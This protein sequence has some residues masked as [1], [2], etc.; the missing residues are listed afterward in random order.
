MTEFEYSVFATIRKI[1]KGCVATYGQIARL[2]GHERASRAVGTAL[3]F[4]PDPKGTPCYR[5]VNSKGQL[6]SAF[7]FGGIEKQKE[8]L[9]KDGIIVKNYKVDLSIYQW[10]Q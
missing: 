8:L 6:A 1:P 9:Q 4:N 7:A 10:E 5:V 3:H 2:A